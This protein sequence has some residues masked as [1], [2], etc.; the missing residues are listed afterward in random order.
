MLQHFDVFLLG[1]ITILSIIIF[2]QT[3]FV[4]ILLKFETFPADVLHISLSC[5]DLLLCLYIFLIFTTEVPHLEFLSSFTLLTSISST[6]VLSL[7]KVLS[8]ACPFSYPSMVTVST[9]V[10]I[11]L[12]S[13]CSSFFI[14]LLL[15]IPNVPLQT[16]KLVIFVILISLLFLSCI[17]LAYVI[18]VAF[19]HK[20]IIRRASRCARRSVH[21]LNSIQAQALSQPNTPKRTESLKKGPT[22]PSLP[23]NNSS[24]ALPEDEILFNYNSKPTSYHTVKISPLLPSVRKP[25][26]SPPATKSAMLPMVCLFSLLL[27][28]TPLLA[29]QF[30]SLISSKVP[31]HWLHLAFV[32][33]L[34]L[35]V[36]RPHIE[37]KARLTE[38]VRQ[39]LDR[40][41][42]GRAA[43]EFERENLNQLVR[44]ARAPLEGVH[45]RVNSLSIK[46]RTK[47]RSTDN[48]VRN[49][50]KELQE[51][52]DTIAGKKVGMQEPVSNQAQVVSRDY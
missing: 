20:T 2:V 51:S 23:S 49:K 18:K 7:D 38:T 52:E 37:V 4:V 15:I 21:R 16:I 42:C 44:L 41:L 29:V 39:V 12:L 45:E 33:L 34:V 25:P 5:S 50:N 17:F 30:A 28:W 36:F 31:Q 26:R 3:V 32:P 46:R 43:E 22:E 19:R 6:A 10:K 27:S 47:Q 35:A 8:L 13:W 40:W 24:P 9:L 11:S 48:P 1:I 14:S